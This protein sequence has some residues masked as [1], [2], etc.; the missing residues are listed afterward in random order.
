M[1]NP[2]PFPMKASLNRGDPPSLG[3]EDMGPIKNVGLDDT[4]G[5]P[6]RIPL[7]TPIGSRHP[8]EVLRTK[9]QAKILRELLA[10]CPI[11][12][13]REKGT[14]R[15]MEH[16]CIP[17]HA[18]FGP[19]LLGQNARSGKGGRYWAHRNRIPA[20]VSVA[21]SVD[22]VRDPSTPQQKPVLRTVE[23]I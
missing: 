10:D 20:S 4:K 16:S 22:V 3:R 12:T 15:C 14:P 13:T 7:A 2:P 1:S 9:L 6:P 21:A 5:P 11:S 17:P 8:A 19:F 23:W 18:R